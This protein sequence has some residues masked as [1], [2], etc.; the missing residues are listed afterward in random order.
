M[1]LSDN[2][3]LEQLTASE[4]AIRKGL[5]N[6]PSP[7]QIANLTELARTLERVRAV[8]GPFHVNSAFRSIKVNAAL[9]GSPTSAHLD[10][11]AAD[12]VSVGRGPQEVCK[13]IEGS[14]IP[15]DQ[16]IQ[17]GNWTHI[18]ISPAMRGQILTAH[19]DG[20][21]VSYTTGLV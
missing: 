9:G 8:L 3:T 19:F 1:N 18:A 5:S 14:G 10:G 4:I 13:I 20:G 15:F 7:E 2:F 21:K 17:E 16:L 6:V 11:Y 12:I